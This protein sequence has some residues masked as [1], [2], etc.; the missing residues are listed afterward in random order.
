MT[1]T[2]SISMGMKVMNQYR[3]SYFHHSFRQP[4]S[5][6]IPWL[7][8]TMDF[9]IPFVTHRKASNLWGSN[10]NPK[11]IILPVIS[12]H[13]M[14]KTPH[15]KIGFSYRVIDV[16]PP[17]TKCHVKILIYSSSKIG[18]IS[19]QESKSGYFFSAEN[20]VTESQASTQNAILRSFTLWIAHNKN[21]TCILNICYNLGQEWA[22]KQT[23]W[24]LVRERTIPT[25]RPPFVDEI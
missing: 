22:K 15:T 24:P 10:F 13:A 3:G 6:A 23:P 19:Y 21:T 7:C 17:S 14:S 18:L 5:S 20:A 2:G 1:F 8:W 4:S 16:W 9:N 11:P 12:S 25:D